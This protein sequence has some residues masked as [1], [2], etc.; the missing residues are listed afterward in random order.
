M[1]S[2]TLELT[3]EVYQRADKIINWADANRVSHAEMQKRFDDF[4]DKKL[5]Y[6]PPKESV[7]DI[8][9]G[10][11]AVYSIEEH[12]PGEWWK[13][14]SVSCRD[15]IPPKLAVD[16]IM[17][18]YGFT[19]MVEDCKVWPEEISRTHIAVNVMEP[20]GDWYRGKMN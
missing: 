19:F 12:R 15:P 5:R 13:H 9:R 1:K 16:A 10:F 7:Q 6:D 4:K 18:L 3:K 17:R 11:I 2:H 20:Y 8:E 14:L